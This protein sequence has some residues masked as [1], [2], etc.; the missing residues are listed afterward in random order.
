MV[1]PI[2]SQGEGCNCDAAL[3]PD[4]TCRNRQCGARSGAIVAFRLAVRS[5]LC[6]SVTMLL[7]T[8]LLAYG[9]LFTL[10]AQNRVIADETVEEAGP[11]TVPNVTPVR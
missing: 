3:A 8:L 1:L 7:H 10:I 5:Y 6:T 11:Q 2:N 4:S 9:L